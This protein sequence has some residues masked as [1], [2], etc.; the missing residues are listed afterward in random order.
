VRQD[1]VVHVLEEEGRIVEGV[2]GDAVGAVLGWVLVK[3]LVGD[4][5]VNVVLEG[6]VGGTYSLTSS[7]CSF[8]G[9]MSSI[10]GSSFGYSSRTLERMARWT[11][12]LTLDLA[13]E[14]MLA[15]LVCE[16]RVD[17]G[18]ILLFLEHCGG[19]VV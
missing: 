8:L 16:L 14:V 6:W 5:D 13:P 3:L 18:A 2:E 15:V 9:S 19:F 4:R 7:N 17:F 1:G 10:C 11:L 12:D